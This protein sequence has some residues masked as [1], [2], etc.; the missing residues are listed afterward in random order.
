M[1]PSWHCGSANQN[2]QLHNMISHS[3]ITPQTISHFTAPPIKPKRLLINAEMV[4]MTTID[5][6]HQGLTPTNIA[7]MLHMTWP[8][9][10]KSPE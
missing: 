1:H 6:Q 9:A 10:Y 8:K 5:E 4:K 7:G 3:A 2:T